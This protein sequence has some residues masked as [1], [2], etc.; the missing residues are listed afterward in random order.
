MVELLFFA[1]AIAAAPPAK[2]ATYLP[3]PHATAVFPNARAAIALGTKFRT[4][5][6]DASTV[7][8]MGVA[9]DAPAYA[10]LVANTLVIE[11]AIAN[12]KLAEGAFELA[13]L[14]K[15]AKSL[16]AA[17]GLD[18]SIELSIEKQRWFVAR[19]QD[20]LFLSPSRD[21]WP[22][23]AIAAAQA[24]TKPAEPPKWI[25]AIE[26]TPVAWF[27]ARGVE[28]VERIEGAVLAEGKTIDVRVNAALDF[29]SALLLSD[30]SHAPGK[31]RALFK[32]PSVVA[33]L[34]A[35]LPG[36]AMANAFE[37]S[38]VT[39]GHSQ[40]A[41]G[42][43]HVALTKSGVL[44]AAVEPRESATAEQ[45]EALKKALAAKLDGVEV[46]VAPAPA[47]P[48]ADERAPI[49]LRAKPREL[50]DGLEARS[51][52]KSSIRPLRPEVAVARSRLGEVMSKIDT[53]K[54]ELAV[55]PAGIEVRAWMTGL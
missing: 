39:G 22:S 14:K 47:N 11:A 10:Y 48:P 53:A 54:M 36:S 46:R 35:F 23:T 31:S 2:A 24:A 33:E 1:A 25:K 52:T 38:G 32:E 37:L 45:K 44:I 40:H 6:F 42:R 49:E 28:G 17:E 4:A 29:A 41:S 12:E 34:T 3:T 43:V 21:A 20:R 15:R 13:L 7:E 18:R 51:K 26:K 50:L 5:P 19:A 16:P 55:T 9:L 8:A 30:L 27:T